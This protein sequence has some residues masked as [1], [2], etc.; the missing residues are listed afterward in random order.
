MIVIIAGAVPGYY[1]LMF[2]ISLLFSDGSNTFYSGRWLFLIGTVIC[3]A[4][5]VVGAKIIFSGISPTY[6]AINKRGSD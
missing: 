2:T 1:F 4:L 5:L 3:A 6:K